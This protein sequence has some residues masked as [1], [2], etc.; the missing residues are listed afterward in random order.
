M[1]FRMRARCCFYLNSLH[2]CLESNDKTELLKAW[3]LDYWLQD[4]KG[5][6]GCLLIIG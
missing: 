3:P 4:Y 1:L 6:E 2:Q 5:W